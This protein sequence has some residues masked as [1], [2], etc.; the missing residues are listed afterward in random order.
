MDL[1]Y[2]EREEL[3]RGAFLEKQSSLFYISLGFI[4][5]IDKKIPQ[6]R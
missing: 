6:T 5:Y 1:I 4:E 2:K 3:T